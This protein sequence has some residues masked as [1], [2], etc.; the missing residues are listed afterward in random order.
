MVALLVAAVMMVSAASASEIALPVAWNVTFSPEENSKFDAVA[1]TADGGYIVLGSTLTG[2][3]EDLLLV[4]TDGRG[5]EIWTERF[6]GMAAASVAETADGGYI[7][8]GYNATAGQ[9]Q[10][11]A[12]QGSSLLI[13]TD[14]AGKEE[15]RQVLQNEKVSVVRPTADGGYVITGWLWD[16]PGSANDTTAVIT[17]TDGNGT[18][19]WSRTF[20]G[21]AANTGIVTADGGYVIGGT[22]S[23]FTYDLGDAFLI[24]LDAG[25]NTLWEKNYAVPVIFDVEETG[26]GGFVYSGNFWYGLVDAKGEE[27]WLRN[28]EGLA[29]YAVALRPAGGY[30][31]AGTDIRSGEAFAFGTDGDGIVRWKT[32]IPGARVYAADSAP[33]GYVLAGIRQVPPAMGAAWLAGLEEAPASTPAAPGFGA[34]AAGAALLLL[35]LAGRTRR[36]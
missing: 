34:I 26:K 9:D 15:W 35:L 24:R 12:R 25:G 5:N 18:P 31:I 33:G 28:M 8:A 23:P 21:A 16:L 22:K 17:K 2:S 11:A 20:P 32:T 4:K 30:M 7:V 6:P 19:T 1:G 10:N 3:G 14:A 36:E 13:R 29:G 27:V